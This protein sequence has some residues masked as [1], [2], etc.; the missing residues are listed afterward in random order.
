MEVNETEIIAVDRNLYRC[1]RARSPTRI[2]SLKK[3]VGDIWLEGRHEADCALSLEFDQ[4]VSS[5][6]CQPLSLLKHDRLKPKKNGT[7]RRYTPD[8]L[9][10]L[11]NGE[12]EFWEVKAPDYRPEDTQDILRLFFG[13][14]MRQG[15][16]LKVVTQSDY[17]SPT[18]V[19]NLRRIH[20]YR[21]H[22][23]EDALWL[24]FYKKLPKSMLFGELDEAMRQAGFFCTSSMN[25]LWE[26]RVCFDI[27][28]ELITSS[29]IVEITK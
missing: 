1:S 2:S 8:F 11:T 24:P 18:K 29:S 10:T 22:R 21:Y 27:D 16:R 26:Q 15:Y 17:G 3:A 19:R 5:F 20:Q 12:K 4:S 23:F 13:D 9:V 14:L 7:R 6:R 28:N 25:A